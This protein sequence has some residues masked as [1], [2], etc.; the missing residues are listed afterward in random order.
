MLKELTGCEK[1]WI[2]ILKV[3]RLI[4]MK[5]TTEFS[6]I[7]VIGNDTLNAIYIYLSAGSMWQ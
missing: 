5:L 7:G 1:L 4:K 6:K 3:D 2:S